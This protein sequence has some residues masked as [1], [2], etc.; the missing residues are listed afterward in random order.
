MTDDSQESGP[1]LYLVGFMASG[2]TSTGRRLAGQLNLQFIDSDEAIEQEMGKPITEIFSEQG[3]EAF[4]SMERSFMETGHP[5]TGCVVSCGGGLVVP[6]G[7][8]E[9]VASKGVSICLSATPETILSRTRGRDN[10]PLLNV[11]DPA[12]RI[13]ELLEERNPRYQAVGNVVPT[14]ERTL[15]E[16]VDKVLQI[17]EEARLESQ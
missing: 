7:M 4:R 17:Y 10:R 2:K 6:P 12:K 13:R 5:P 15:A 9:L 8:A 16:V 1:N 3:E 11:P 14:D